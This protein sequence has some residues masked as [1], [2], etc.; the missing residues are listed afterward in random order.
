MPLLLSDNQEAILEELEN[1]VKM[2]LQY[3]IHVFCVNLFFHQR[4]FQ[5]LSYSSEAH[6]F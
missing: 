2:I 5:S 4:S 1:E 6:D 3:H